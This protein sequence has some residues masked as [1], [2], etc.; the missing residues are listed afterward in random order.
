MWFADI[1]C[2][3]RWSLCLVC[4]ICKAFGIYSV[5]R[6]W[7]S[8]QPTL[9]LAVLLGSTWD[10]SSSRVPCAFFDLEWRHGWASV[11]LWFGLCTKIAMPPSL[12]S[13]SWT[14]IRSPWRRCCAARCCSNGS[15]SGLEGQTNGS[16]WKVRA[17]WLGQWPKSVYTCTH[18]HNEQ[19]LFFYVLHPW[20]KF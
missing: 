9:F 10:N 13:R 17:K 11:E 1:G 16:L 8:S 20:K 4:L 2:C 14:R 3:G 12:L 7:V 18:L 5:S 6:A 19:T 15:T